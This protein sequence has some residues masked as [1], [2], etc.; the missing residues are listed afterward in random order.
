MNHYLLLLLLCTIILY[1]SQTT[2]S[3]TTTRNKL[4]FRD[5]WTSHP[6][7]MLISF[8]KFILCDVINQY[9]KIYIYSVF[10]NTNHDI[11]INNLHIQ[12]SGESYFNDPSKYDI[13][14]I[15][16][17]ESENVI[18]N[19]LAVIYMYGLEKRGMLNLTSRRLTLK[20]YF[21]AFVVTN[22][23]DNERLRFFVE[24]TKYKLVHSCGKCRNNIDHEIP[25]V[26]TQE[27]FDYLSQ[28]KFM[29]CFENKSQV[30]YFTEKLVNAYNGGT[31][32]IYYGCPQVSEWINLKS[33]IY[34]PSEDQFQTAISKIIQLDTHD[35]LYRQMFNEPLFKDG[36]IPKELDIYN[37]RNKVNQFLL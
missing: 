20:K 34:I 14:F 25:Q 9:D 32:P 31:I 18:L 26:D 21:C 2:M 22:C 1:M 28:F 13:N 16:S 33:I 35:D 8:F 27:Y 36:K 24:L 11:N 4:E 19:P 12:Y 23:A 29:I 7:E 3:Q 17:M 6:D 37:I 10:G 15:P 30:N 5:L